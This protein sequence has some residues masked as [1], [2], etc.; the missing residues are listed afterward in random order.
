[1]FRKILC[2]LLIVLTSYLVIGQSPSALGKFRHINKYYPGQTLYDLANSPGT[3]SAIDYYF[4]HSYSVSDQS[5]SSCPLDSISFFNTLLFDIREFEQMR[6]QSENT[7][8]EFK[9]FQIEL[10]SIDNV[11]AELGSYSIDQMA[12]LR[13]LRPLPKF[14]YSGNLEA[15][16]ATYSHELDRWIRD[17]PEEYRALTSTEGLIR[18]KLDQFPLLADER[19]VL[20]ETLDYIIIK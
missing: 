16:Y 19:K 20:L 6:M 15:D 11:Q 3:L 12:D 1:M 5:C 14:V 9:G 10:E 18:V 13:V 7:S 8:I 17:F 4:N 2:S